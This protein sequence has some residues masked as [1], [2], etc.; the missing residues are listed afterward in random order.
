MKYLPCIFFLMLIM[1]AKA[2]TNTPVDNFTLVTNL[3]YNGYK[4]E[5]LAIADQRLAVNSN[6]L[7]GLVLKM[8]YD[9]SF[10]NTQTISNDMLNVIAVAGTITN[11]QVKLH[12]NEMKEILEDFL[13]I[14]KDDYHPTTEEIKEDRAKAL[15]PHKRMTHERYLKW[16]H[17]DGLF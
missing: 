14:L 15:L 13:L 5:V 9:F 7:A 17:E 3:W 4:T 12:Y 1:A 6:D 8:E 16:L 2:Q 11:E 10:V